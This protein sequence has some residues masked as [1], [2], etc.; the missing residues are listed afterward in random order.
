MISNSLNLQILFLLPLLFFANPGTA[1]NNPD[2][3]V[4]QFFIDYQDKGASEALDNLYSNNPWMNRKTDAVSN[5]KTQ[6]E[7]LNESFV[8]QFFGFEKIV[9]KRLTGSYVL[10]SYLAKYDRQPVRFTFQFYKPDDKWRTF[11]FQFDT[12]ID[13]EIEEAAKLYY[14]DLNK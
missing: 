11:S 1:Q 9:E 8:G 4:E 14:L 12:D 3:I 13:D 6:L 2:E 5:L 7:A 10:L